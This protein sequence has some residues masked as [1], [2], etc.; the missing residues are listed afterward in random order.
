MRVITWKTSHRHTS[1]QH[2]TPSIHISLTKH[3]ADRHLISITQAKQRMSQSDN[4]VMDAHNNMAQH[5]T[6]RH[7][8]N[9]TLGRYN[10]WSKQHLVG[11]CP[12][13]TTLLIDA[14]NNMAQH[15]TERH[16]V[17]MTLGLH[18]PQQQD[19]RWTYVFV[20]NTNHMSHEEHFTNT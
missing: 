2:D 12:R 5:F 14:C 19:T 6:D 9:T 15:L 17:N 1:R 7:L 3:L 18:I 16:L 20:K 10:T 8:V 11:T 13:L 4:A